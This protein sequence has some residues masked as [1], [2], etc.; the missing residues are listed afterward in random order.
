MSF[1]YP[2][3]D[4]PAS[5]V[6]AVCCGEDVLAHKEKKNNFHIMTFFFFFLIVVIIIDIFSNCPQYIKTC[7]C[8]DNT[9]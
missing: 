6:A 5:N 3:H 2:M 9:V 8:F 1:I 4:L 7:V